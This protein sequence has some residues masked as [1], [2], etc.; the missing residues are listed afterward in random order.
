MYLEGLVELSPYDKPAQ[1]L[2]G[3]LLW[4]LNPLGS[5][6]PLPDGIYQTFSLFIDTFLL[7]R[8]ID[9]IYR[10]FLDII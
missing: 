2:S 10:L 1:L 3:L 7:F 4:S 8:G 9:I 6:S 5:G